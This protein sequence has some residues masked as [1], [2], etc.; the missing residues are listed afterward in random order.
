MWGAVS[1][2]ATSVCLYVHDAFQQVPFR[3]LSRHI[4]VTQFA[5]ADVLVHCNFTIVPLF[6]VKPTNSMG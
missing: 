4:N 3:M 2:Q 5:A 6:V 1:M